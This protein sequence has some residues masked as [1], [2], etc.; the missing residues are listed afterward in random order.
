MVCNRFTTGDR[1]PEED[2]KKWPFYDDLLFL[3]DTVEYVEDEI[4]GPQNDELAK[5]AA[6][7]PQAPWAAESW[8]GLRDPNHSFVISLLEML[9]RI[10][11]KMAL[12]ILISL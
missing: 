9:S 10:K 1:G 3:K 11:N 8:Q 7:R 2:A 4:T 6:N 12:A 5:T